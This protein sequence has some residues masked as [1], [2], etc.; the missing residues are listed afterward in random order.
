MT[1]YTIRTSQHLDR[2]L[3]EVFDFFARPENLARLTPRGLGFELRSTDRRMR[4]GLVIEYRIR[5]LLNFAIGWTSGISEYAPGSRFVDVQLR[6][7]YRTWRHVHE[8]S[9]EAGGTR[10]DDEVTYSLPLGPLGEAV[11]ALVVRPS[12]RQIFGF[13]RAAMQRLLPRR[14]TREGPM[15]VA[16]AGGSG[17][18][19]GEIA[20][21]LDRRGH[22]VIVLSHRPEAAGER[23]PDGIEIREADVTRADG[24]ADA[25][26]GVDALVIAI[27][28][29]N[30]PI[31]EPA[32]DHTFETVDAGGT[33][34]LAAAAARSGIRRLVYISGVGAAPDAE[35]HW[36]RAKWR[37][38]TAVRGSGIDFTIIRPTWIFG[39]RDVSLNRFLGFAR[40]LAFV[41]LSNFGGQLMAPV[42]VRDVA[43]LA[44]DA[45]QD[46]AARNEVF[47]IAG[48]EAMP[49]RDVIRRA[50]RVAEIW[51]PLLPAPAPLVKLV[52][53]VL[54]RLPGRL[55][56]PDAIDFVN[57]PAVADNRKLLERM[58]RRLTPF[59]DGLRTYLTLDGE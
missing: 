39:P 55:L 44:A 42:F 47:E 26:R 52:A 1:T 25:L 24:L 20:A 15:T 59:E 53:A 12:L 17:F 58:P 31:E 48:P 19:G 40:A 14:E 56:T 38:E 28:F 10:I 57:Q 43:A 21:E 33:E 41:P 49:M 54:Q 34:H 23:L 22:R 18:V 11:H 2:P 37:A 9:E 50:L 51:R 6:G 29:P 7:P 27:A 32:R 8:F 5:P 45:L 16:V 3:A 46:D 30:L 35:R 36:F 4:P 13:R